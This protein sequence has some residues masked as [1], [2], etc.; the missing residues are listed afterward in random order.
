MCLF[1]P[2]SL[3]MSKG[4]PATHRFFP[5]C[6]GDEPDRYDEMDAPTLVGKALPEGLLRSLYHD[7]ARKKQKK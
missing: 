1:R 3:P 7:A 5:F 4:T 2:Y 6:T